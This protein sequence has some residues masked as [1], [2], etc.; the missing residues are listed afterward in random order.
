VE[1][2][3][4]GSVPTV[5]R[6]SQTP[7]YDQ[8]RD[9]RLNADV[10]PSDIEVSAPQA[11]QEP[12]APSVLRLVPAGEPGAM[13]VCGVSSEPE[14]DLRVESE[15]FGRHPRHH[16]VDEVPDLHGSARFARRPSAQTADGGLRGKATVPTAP[17]PVHSERGRYPAS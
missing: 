1:D 7:L 5:S 8:L 4:A 11:Q 15:C 13:A 10:P 12:R 3:F 14:A 6:V 9:E 2:V 16:E 17:A